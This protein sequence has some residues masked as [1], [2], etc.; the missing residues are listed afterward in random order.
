[1]V[2]MV[3]RVLEND[4]YACRGVHD[5]LGGL[6]LSLAGGN[7]RVCEVDWGPW[8][9]TDTIA[10]VSADASGATVTT[11]NTDTAVTLTIS[12]VRG[13][14]YVRH[15]ITTTDGLVRTLD[16]ETREIT[17]RPRISGYA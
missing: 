12:N 11:A 3:V 4:R 17:S 14:G 7:T 13:A 15:T 6:S 16:I 9:G 8:L 10:S 5:Y 1:M 2:D